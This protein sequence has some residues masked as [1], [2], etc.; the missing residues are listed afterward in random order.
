MTHET[1][2]GGG[3][4]ER[5]LNM[6]HSQSPTCQHSAAS[7]E[8]RK[9]YPTFIHLLSTKLKLFIY[10]F[11][12]FPIHV[13]FLSLPLSIPPLPLFQLTTGRKEGRTV[14]VRVHGSNQ[15]ASQNNTEQSVSGRQPDGARAVGPF[16]RLSILIRDRE[17]GEGDKDE[18]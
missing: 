16:L 8:F 5:R 4:E 2:E 13:A 6:E 7:R 14:G 11:P 3:R 18:E 10:A 9:K 17:C 15:P 12:S 1:H